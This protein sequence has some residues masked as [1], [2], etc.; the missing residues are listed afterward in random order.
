MAIP[1]RD[2]AQRIGR[3]LLAL[4]RQSVRADHLVLLLNNCTDNTLE[5]VEAAPQAAGTVHIVVCSLAPEQASAGIARRLATSHAASL[6]DEGVLLTTD[7]DAEVPADWIEANLR[8]VAQGSDAVC[9]RALI[10]PVDALHIPMHLHE[11]DAREV[12]FAQLLNRMRAILLP[13]RADLWPR[14][15]ESSGA[16][17][18]I[19]TSMFRRVGGVPSIP[20]GEDRGLIERVRMLDGRV[21]HDPSICVTVSGRVE[22]RAARGMAETI[23][24]RMLKQDEFVDEAYEPAFDALRRLRFEQRYQRLREGARSG[25][26]RGGART[27]ATELRVSTDLLANALLCPYRGAGWAMLEEASPALRRKRVAFAELPREITIARQLLR[28][29][30]IRRDPAAS[31]A[32]LLVAE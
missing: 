28:S 15:T 27:L 2:E 30:A 19:T 11:D 10:D 7:A 3:C 24:R 25:R 12:A 14:H 29:F 13:D 6:L 17:I 9:G 16:S 31:G 22:G 32:S 26:S 20:S 8:A 1:V 4:A 18:A 23:R 5:R 21:R